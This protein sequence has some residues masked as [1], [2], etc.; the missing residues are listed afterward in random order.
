MYIHVFLVEYSNQVRKAL[1]QTEPAGW[2]FWQE[3]Q[4]CVSTTL[5]SYLYLKALS[6]YA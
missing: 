6:S 1:T 2:Y 3:M 5:N 4:N